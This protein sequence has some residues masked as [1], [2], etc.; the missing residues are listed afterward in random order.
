MTFFLNS[1]ITIRV[2]L[3]LTLLPTLVLLLQNIYMWFAT[4]CPI[5]IYIYP[6]D[7]IINFLNLLL[8]LE[9][10]VQ[11]KSETFFIFLYFFIFFFQIKECFLPFLY[12]RQQVLLFRSPGYNNNN[13]LTEK[14]SRS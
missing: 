11:I 4:S 10:P 14:S 1:F 6:V 3:A 2:I 9:Y 12:L 8:I 7:Y 5:V 13:N